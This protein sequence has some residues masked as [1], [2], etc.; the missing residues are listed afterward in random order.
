MTTTNMSSRDLARATY[1]KAIEE[2]AF[3]STEIARLRQIYEDATQLL[4]VLAKVLHEEP[5]VA[6]PPF[7]TPP[8]KRADSEKPTSPTNAHEGTT[9]D[10]ADSMRQRVER[11][12]DAIVA[13]ISQ[14]GATTSAEI[15]AHLAKDGYDLGSYPNGIVADDARILAQTGRITKRRRGLYDRAP[16]QTQ[17]PN[18][19]SPDIAAE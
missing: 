19:S 14:R 1:E 3:A 15:M 17:L 16:I 10:S 6:P 8:A 13:F 18:L 7:N 5:I 9:A 4:G 12:R 2:Q 11:R